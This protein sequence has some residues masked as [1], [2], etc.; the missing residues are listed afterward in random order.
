MNPSNNIGKPLPIGNKDIIRKIETPVAKKK[1]IDLRDSIQIKSINLKHKS[2]IPYGKDSP[3]NRSDISVGNENDVDR[4]APN[5]NVIQ[6]IAPTPNN[7]NS[8][9]TKPM[10]SSRSNGRLRN[11]NSINYK[12]S[13]RGKRSDAKSRSSR[14]GTF[15]AQSAI[16]FSDF[17]GYNE[18]VSEV[19]SMKSPKSINLSS[20]NISTNG[21]Q[22]QAGNVQ[23][24]NS[25][26]SNVTSL[27]MDEIMIDSS[28]DEAVSVETKKRRAS[29]SVFNEISGHSPYTEEELEMSVSDYVMYRCELQIKKLESKTN[30][31][32][33]DF[34]NTASIVRSEMQ[35]Y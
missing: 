22:H 23:S 20:E 6:E 11:L 12:L 35:K 27:Y 4:F 21:Y 10:S 28:G 7:S 25:K 18:N 17:E 24:G 32:I 13:L 30:A 26:K 16:S 14:P 3:P 29:N 5:N 1:T 31:L 8:Q 34:K 9:N 2:G 33:D 19:E 15:D